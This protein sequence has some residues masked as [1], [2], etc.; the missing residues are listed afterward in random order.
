VTD[1]FNTSGSLNWNHS[2]TTSGG[3]AYSPQSIGGSNFPVIVDPPSWSNDTSSGYN[4]STDDRV[5][6][7]FN[8]SGASAAS[9]SFAAYVDTEANHDLFNISSKAAGGDPFSGGTPLDSM[10]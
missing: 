7:S 1:S 3:W 10:S 5:Y 6:K 2:T 9:A 8:L 4:D